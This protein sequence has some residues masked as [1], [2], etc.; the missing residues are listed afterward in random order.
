[1]ARRTNKMTYCARCRTSIAIDPLNLEKLGWTRRTYR[2]KDRWLCPTCKE[3][4]ARR[5]KTNSVRTS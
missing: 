3:D 1:M 2:K 5:L 4:V